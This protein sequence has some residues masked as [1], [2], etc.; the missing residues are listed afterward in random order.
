MTLGKLHVF[1]RQFRVIAVILTAFFMYLTWDMWEWFQMNH[2]E[3]KEWTVA[4]FSSLVLLAAG[5]VKW[6]L[7]Q[8]FKKIEKDEH[9]WE[10]YKGD[11][12]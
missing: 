10:K 2:D 6:S 4:G 7:E 12:E 3:L 1:L 9:D 11:S 8:F 5:T